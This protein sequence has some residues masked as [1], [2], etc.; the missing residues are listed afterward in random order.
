MRRIG[1]LW[2]LVLCL[3]ISGA[4]AA[5]EY[6]LGDPQQGDYYTCAD[7]DAEMPDDVAEIFS[8]LMREGDEVICGSRGQARNNRLEEMRWDTILMAVRREGKVLLL[9]AYKRDG[10]WEACVETDSFI[11]ADMSFDI[12]YLPEEK[13]ENWLISAEHAIV[14]GNES[15]R[16]EVLPRGRVSWIYYTKENPDGSKYH[17]EAD[18]CGLSYFQIWN[19]QKLDYGYERCSLPTVLTAWTMD[20]IP[21]NQM[22][23]KIWAADHQPFVNSGEGYICGVNLRTKPT[24]SSDSLGKYSAKVKVLGKQPGTQAPW[25][26]VRFGD[27]EGWVSGDYFVDGSKYDI[28][29]FGSFVSCDPFA[30]ADEEIG[31]YTTAGGT[32]KMRIPAGTLM[33]VFHQDED[34]LHVIIPDREINWQTNWN[35]IYGFVHRDDVTV[36]QTLTDLKWK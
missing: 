33:H 35:G 24:G 23:Q 10:D 34:W 20:T 28:R 3:M 13:G 1:L 7:F 32:D 11:P 36:G 31:L 21:K 15:Y 12:T 17:M 25:V 29:F 22:D 4:Q 14:C 16:I 18:S 6:T 8:S 30:R 5:Q 9:G 2:L 26:H 19:G 27:T